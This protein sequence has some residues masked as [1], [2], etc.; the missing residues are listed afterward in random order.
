M[1]RPV[2]RRGLHEVRKQHE[3]A[4]GKLPKQLLEKILSLQVSRVTQ[5]LEHCVFVYSPLFKLSIRCLCFYFF[6]GRHLFKTQEMNGK[7][8]ESRRHRITGGLG[9]SGRR[10]LHCRLFFLLTGSFGVPTSSFHVPARTCLTWT[11]QQVKGTTGGKAGVKGLLQAA[12]C[13]QNSILTKNFCLQQAAAACEMRAGSPTSASFCP[14][15]RL[16]EGRNLML[17]LSIKHTTLASQMM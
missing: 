15:S 17:V 4:I 2:E 1:L 7:V 11:V 16:A 14:L 8:A 10:T 6:T 3:I 12:T 5:I 13:R 9:Q